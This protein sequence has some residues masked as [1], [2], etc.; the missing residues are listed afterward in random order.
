MNVT[1]SIDEETLA[2][3]QELASRRGT[4]LDQMIVDYLEDLTSRRPAEE[5]VEELKEFW[6]KNTG[7]SETVSWTREEI[8]ERTGIR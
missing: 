2:K 7:T 6:S 1:L 5:I 3:A 4:S 8:H